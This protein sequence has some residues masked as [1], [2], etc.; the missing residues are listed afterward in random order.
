MFVCDRDGPSHFVSRAKFVDLIGSI[1]ALSP[2]PGSN[3]TT[4]SPAQRNWCPNIE[5]RKNL[6]SDELYFAPIVVV[7]VVVVDPFDFLLR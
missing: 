4:T 6:Q 1:R 2:F 3:C 5:P 7:A